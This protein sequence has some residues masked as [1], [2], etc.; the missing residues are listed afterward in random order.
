MVID[1]DGLTILISVIIFV[2]A[3]II[4]KV[5]TKKTYIYFIFLSVMFLYLICVV[6][7]TVFP[8]YINCNFEPNLY[9]SINWIP[10][11]HFVLRDAVMNFVMAI[12]FGFGLQFF[13]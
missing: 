8:L 5:I 6:R 9:Q 3:S 4:L 7:L 12:P 13:I 11:K 10:F 2:V 1:F